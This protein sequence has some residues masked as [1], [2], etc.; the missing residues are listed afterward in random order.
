[1]AKIYQQGALNTTSLT[2]PNVYVQIQAPVTLL[3]GVSSSRIGVVGTASW[4][5]VNTPVVV[6]GMPDYLL[7]FGAKQALATDM[8][9]NV[10]ICVYQGA[11]DFRCVR[12]TDGTDKAATGTISG[13]TITAVYTGTAGNAI[14]A[15]L[16]QG[17]LNT[18]MWTLTVTHS[19]LGTSTYQGTTWADIV[20]AVNADASALVVVTGGTTLAAGNVT[21]AGGADGGTPA[22]TAFIGTDGTS[23]TGMYALRNQG[24]AIGLLCG[25]SDKTSFFAQIDF[26]L[27]EG[28]YMIAAL[29]SGTSVSAATSALSGAG[30]DSY[31]M[32]VMHGDW[33]WWDDDTNGNMLVSPA[34][35]AAGLLAALSPEQSTL[36]KQLYGIIG[37]QKAGLTSSGTLLS[38]S[39]AELSALFEAGI[40]VICYPAPGGN[41]WAV[42]GG[43]NCSTSAAVNGDNYTR[44]TNY[45]AETFATGM[46]SYIGQTINAD[47]FTNIEATLL[48]F[49]SNMLTEGVLGSTD[50]STPYSV[51]C[52]TSNNPDSRT[53]LGYVQADVKVKYMGILRYFIVNLQGGQGVTVTVASGG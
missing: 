23:R 53:A 20:A 2:V 42:R 27:G 48:G 21:L 18:A 22:A 19:V 50:G 44:L 34:A 40:D 25:L 52:D 39:D 10:N 47:L 41:Y 45:L 51:V 11:S 8:G 43:I 6:G 9:V 38:Y 36:N 3:N 15:T 14:T 7:V 31:A 32:K 13:A 37:S 24:C 26:G 30:A 12:V 28:L 49:L 35:F 5:P 17:T 29:P 4:G 46:G 1:M 16:S 33:I